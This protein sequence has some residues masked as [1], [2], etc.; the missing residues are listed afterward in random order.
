M[1]EVGLY[2]CSSVVQYLALVGLDARLDLGF[3]GSVFVVFI[4]RHSVGC[5][6]VASLSAR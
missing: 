4:G 5:V 2:W 6:L 3:V 1:S